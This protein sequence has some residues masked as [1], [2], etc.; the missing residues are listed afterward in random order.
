MKI[1]RSRS[2]GEMSKKNVKK[3]DMQI[4]RIK[5]KKAFQFSNFV[6]FWTHMCPFSKKLVEIKNKITS[7]IPLIYF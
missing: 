2:V 3:L 1:M 6:P 4:K 7:H 5:E